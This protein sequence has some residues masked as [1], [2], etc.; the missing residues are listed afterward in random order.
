M[1]EEREHRDFRIAMLR[2]FLNRCPKC[3]RGRLFGAFLKVEDHCSACGEALYHQR[4]D[5]APAYFVILIVGHIVVPLMLTVEFALHPPYWVH[6]VLWLPLTLA[7]ALGLIQP[8]KGAIIGLQW[9]NRMH[10][11]DAHAEDETN[12][13]PAKS[14]GSA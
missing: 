5:D 9:A 13:K 1:D 4:A 6:L 2:G 7:L 8:I 14:S 3:G 12:L 10:G 11:F